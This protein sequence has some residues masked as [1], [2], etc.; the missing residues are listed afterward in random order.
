MMSAPG[1]RDL[2]CANTAVGNN[3]SRGRSVSNPIKLYVTL[4]TVDVSGL[5]LPIKQ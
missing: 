4:G 3:K 5:K 2:K 1:D